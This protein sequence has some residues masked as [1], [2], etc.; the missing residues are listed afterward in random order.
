MLVTGTY[1]DVVR[2]YES[3]CRQYNRT[4]VGC[5][6]G[7][8]PQDAARDR[9]KQE[10]LYLYT[11]AATLASRP[12]VAAFLQFYLAHADA[13]VAGLSSSGD[14]AVAA[15]PAAACTA[16]AAAQPTPTATAK[17]APVPT[18]AIALPARDRIVFASNRDSANDLYMMNVDGT[19][20]R[21]LTTDIGYL[22]G[23]SQ[24][25]DRL[26]Y[27]TERPLPDNQRRVNFNLIRPDGSGRTNLGGFEY[28]DWD[29]A[30]SR[31][32]RKVAFVTSRDG[33]REIYV[34]DLASRQ[35]TR[36]T[37]DP[38]GDYSPAWTPDGQ[39]IVFA[40]ERDMP[41]GC[42][43]PEIYTM[44]AADGSDLQRLTS[45]TV[46]DAHPKVSPDGASIAFSTDRGGAR[47]IYVMD[48]D[49]KNACRLTTSPWMDQYPAWS[50]DG[51]WLVFDR[52]TGESAAQLFVVD[53]RGNQLRQ[54]TSDASSN[55]GAI[56]LPR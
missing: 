32:G 49:G 39:R 16:F 10:P 30:F 11:D 54:I 9:P 15:P 42:N 50:G 34:L 3:R 35:V 51:K 4:L 12:R 14:Y 19:G 53:S 36:L 5:Q 44:N 21:R 37:R 43:C 29:P 25:A 46:F 18:P 41:E 33:N 56:W 1:T 2:P 31:D 17:P 40:S 48:V 26:V 24:G 20:L 6:V 55:W 52:R 38:A 28:D 13:A 22:P 8:R 47:S 7:W 45:N 23:Y 27:T